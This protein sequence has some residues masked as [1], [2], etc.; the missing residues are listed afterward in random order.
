MRGR[1]RVVG[2]AI[3]K[4]PGPLRSRIIKAE[5]AIARQLDA[6]RQILTVLP[7]ESWVAERARCAPKA[8]VAVITSAQ[9]IFRFQRRSFLLSW[10]NT[11]FSIRLRSWETVF[12]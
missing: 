9:S 8:R 7:M 10:M 11:A 2:S 6:I 5:P 12:F 1:E 4:N 3:S